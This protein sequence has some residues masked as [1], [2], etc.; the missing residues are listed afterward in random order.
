MDKPQTFRIREVTSAGHPVGSTR[1]NAQYVLAIT[2]VDF[3]AMIRMHGCSERIY[4][5]DNAKDVFNAW[6]GAS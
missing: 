1:I 6:K 3:G 5:D 4:T 2:Q